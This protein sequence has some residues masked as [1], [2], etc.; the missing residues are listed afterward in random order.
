MNNSNSLAYQV[1]NKDLQSK[2][3][4]P[5]KIITYPQ[6]AN[7]T[8]I[9]ELLPNDFSILVILIETNANAGHW[10][11]I[12]K[13]GK[14][15][16]FFDSYGLKYDNELKFINNTVKQQ[17]HETPFLTPLFNKAKEE[18]FKIIYNKKRLQ[19]FSPNINTCGKWVTAVANSFCDGLDLSQFLKILESKK[20][21]SK[22]SYDQIVNSLYQMF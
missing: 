19:E 2:I 3:H 6:L 17:L 11:L 1:S 16:T 8:D 12:S 18:G 10:V 14:V 4:H 13:K 9:T 15:I 22:L 21:E 5:I 20:K 7:C